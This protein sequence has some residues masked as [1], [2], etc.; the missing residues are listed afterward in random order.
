QHAHNPV[1]WFEWGAEA[2]DKAV[3]EDKPILVSIGYSSCHWCH[4]MERESF[5]VEA[6]AEL[7]NETCVCIKVDREERP[8]IDQIYM[9]AVQAFGV[10]GGWPLNVFLTPQQKPFFGGT[11]FTPQAWIQILQNIGKA[12]LMNRKHLEETAEEL[13]L[14]LSRSD[15][16]RFVQKSSAPWEKDLEAMFTK[17]ASQFD[18]TW[19]GM[20]KAPKFV[21]PSVWHFL[22]QYHYITKSSESMDQV[23]LT[24]DKVAAGGIYDQIGGGFARYSVD[25][26]WFAPHFEKMLYDNAQLLS[27]YSD[28]YALTKD[29]AY[30]TVVYET[31]GWLMREMSHTDGGFYSALDAD[32]EGVEGQYYVW[33]QSEIEE[34]LGPNA[35]AVAD[36]YSVTANGNWEHGNNI[37]IRNTSKEISKPPFSEILADAKQRML[38]V[39]EKRVKPGLDDKIITSWN[40]MMICGL[41]DAYSAFGDERFLA[42]ALKNMTFIES[43]LSYDG[44]LYRSYK[45]KRSSTPG[46]LDDYAYVIQAQLNLYHVTFDES[47]IHKAAKLIPHVLEN[48][49]DPN[50]GFFFYTSAQSEKLITRKKE[51]FDNVIPSSNA[52]MAHNLF[53]AGS[54][55]DNEDWKQ[56]AF[57]MTEVLGQIITSEPNYMSQ[58]AIVYIQIRHGVNEVLLT[59]KGIQTLR[60]AIQKEY[61]PFI[62]LQGSSGPSSLPLFE[63]KTTVGDRDTIYVCY[64]KTCGLPVHTLE[65]ARKQI[66]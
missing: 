56:K 47:W 32:S 58:W 15:V 40:A 28:A 5:E 4:V 18:K 31:F 41:V 44:K 62:L 54:L 48:F 35:G 53:V 11:Y 7:M 49:Y 33:Q 20:D 64:Q 65:D 39:R 63:G 37:L 6:I 23:R 42:A 13:Q 3:K 12:F 16:E 10:N 38:A 59:G 43:H 22:L 26:H 19:G 60:A 27:L 34:V 25:A 24:L 52:I 51:I 21:M 9:D 8:D 61:R 55:L 36:Y 46:F 1:D 30:K 29:D 14:H 45:S 50:D 57:T 17:L 2:L 66:R